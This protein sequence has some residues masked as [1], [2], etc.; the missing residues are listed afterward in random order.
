MS[1]RGNSSLNMNF[2]R[3]E[4]LC[5]DIVLFLP[6][7]RHVRMNSLAVN[8][9]T[10]ILFAGAIDDEYELSTVIQNFL[11]TGSKYWATHSS[12]RMSAHTTHSL[13]H[14]LAPHCP[15]RSRALL[16]ALVRSLAHSLAPE[17]MGK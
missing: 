13:L 3:H 1:I 7:V 12:A 10:C 16:R 11:K 5:V 17:L 2:T 14:S 6:A 15:L 4:F 9:H 8:L